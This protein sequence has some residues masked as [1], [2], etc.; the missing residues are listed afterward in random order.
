MMENEAILYANPGLPS[1][2]A[3]P[4]HL[5]PSTFITLSEKTQHVERRVCQLRGVLIPQGSLLGL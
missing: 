4:T 2:Q 3:M 5:S 1:S